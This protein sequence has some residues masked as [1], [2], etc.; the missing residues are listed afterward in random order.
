MDT[1]D[2]KKYLAGF[3]I[4]GLLAG[5]GLAVVSGTGKAADNSAGGKSGSDVT[6]EQ[7]MPNSGCSGL[8][9]TPTSDATPTGA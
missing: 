7:T 8:K 1:R 6:T 3:S 5:F 9:A 2:L 4:A